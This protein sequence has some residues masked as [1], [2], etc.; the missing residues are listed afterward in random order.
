MTSTVSFKEKIKQIFSVFLWELKSC[1]G[2]LTVY[3]ILAGVFTIIV[4]TMALVGTDYMFA[5]TSSNEQ[6]PLSDKIYAF[7]YGASATINLL[8]IIFTIFYTIKVYSYMHNKRKAD[9]YGP[10]PISRARLYLSKTLSAYIFSIVPALF[11]MAI[12]SIISVCTGTGIKEEV[13]SMYFSLII[14]TL[15]C[16]TSYGLVAACCGTTLN[17]VIMFLVVCIAYPIAMLFVNGTISAFYPGFYL[18]II[19]DSFV[20]NAL[21]PIAAYGGNNRIYWILFSILCIVL[22]TVL[23]M[24]RKSERAQTSFAYYL[25][26]Y[27]IKLLVSFICGM[28]LGTVF[29]SMNV[30]NEGILGF[31]F[32]F[33][34]ASIPAYIIVHL[35]FYKGFK[36]LFITSIPLGALIVVVISGI[37]IF[38][39][40]LFGYN[41]YVPKPEDIKSAGFIDSDY[42]FP[43]NNE[44]M[45]EASKKSADDFTD[46]TTIAQIID[47]HYELKD[48]SKMESTIKFRNV[49]F[50]ILGNAFGDTFGEDAVTFAYRLDNGS[51]VTRYYP[52]SF[53]LYSDEDVFDNDIRYQVQE[54]AAGIMST[55]QYILNYS[56]TANADFTNGK[57]IEEV[58][59]FAPD[60]NGGIYSAVISGSEYDD[61]EIYGYYG[62]EE[63]A[64][65][66]VLQNQII[67]TE[68]TKA[69]IKDLEADDKYLNYV[70]YDPYDESEDYY[71]Y[72]YDSDESWLSVYDGSVLYNIRESYSKD[73]V[74]QINV[75]ANYSDNNSLYLYNDTM[76]TFYIPVTYT[77][78]LEVLRNYGII[79]SENLINERS[80]FYSTIY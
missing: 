59:I 5:S 25:P 80:E 19:S 1:T 50:S 74:C 41:S 34:L 17:S 39:F 56:A 46:S 23:I 58:Q 14:G 62:E 67:M 54:K 77:N 26:C 47:A 31:I 12:I 64:D 40:D 69:F 52:L 30:F 13:T 28:F 63:E 18:N 8:T 43:E 49:W 61:F 16:V 51:V 37:L 32:G 33:V 20:A 60:S 75:T 72:D 44:N 3:S 15:A 66:K 22:G 11:F 70:L 55:K 9:F 7:Q 71:S 38:N 21:N 45:Y 78:T 4:L 6:V 79:D 68:I 48:Y 53:N 24:K 2:T 57:E 76:E 73:I 10:L 29:A 27:L 65:A 36:K 35:I 42:Y